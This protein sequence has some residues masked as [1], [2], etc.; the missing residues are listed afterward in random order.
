MKGM[1][2]KPAALSRSG[3]LSVVQ[4][5]WNYPLAPSAQFSTGAGCNATSLK[6][7]AFARKAWAAAIEAAAYKKFSSVNCDICAESRS[8]ASR[9]AWREVRLEMAEV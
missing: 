5:A 8:E 1:G 6:R 4:L 9:A 7:G 3:V 2:A